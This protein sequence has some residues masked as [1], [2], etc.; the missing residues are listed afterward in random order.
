MRYKDWTYID[1]GEGLPERKPGLWPRVRR[2]MRVGL[3]ILFLVGGLVIAVT[4]FYYDD[5]GDKRA[6]RKGALFSFL[7]GALLLGWT[8]V[9][10]L[11]DV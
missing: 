4:W 8:R 10:N 7:F 11:D 5:P 1:E 3:G 9:R 6:I 2:Y